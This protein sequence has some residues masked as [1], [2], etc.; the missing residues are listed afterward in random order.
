MAIDD[1]FQA[2]TDK[3]LDDRI[4]RPLR[5]PTVRPSFGSSVWNTTKA[6]FTG[7]GAGANESVGFAADILGA[8]GSVQAG[9]GLQADPTLLF[10]GAEKRREEG[11]KARAD[12][13]SGEAFSTELG[14]GFRATARS[15]SPDPATAN[16][17][18]QILFGLGRFATKA[19]GYSLAAGPVP[20]AV[21]AGADEGMTEADRLKAEGVDLST[22][23][24]V[25][26][27]AGVSTA[28]AVALP[29]AGKTLP[30]TI[31]LVA[32]GGPGGFIAQQ[33]A[34]RAILEH[35]DYGKIAEQYDPFDPVGLAVSTLVPAAF[36]AYALRGVRAAAKSPAASDPAAA[37]ELVQ[38]AGNER[39]AL[40]YDDP[41][42]DAYAITAAQ[43]EGIPPEALLAIKNVGEKS[44]P[45]A[46]SPKGAKGVMQFMDD[47][48][49]SY[50][51]GDARDPVASIDAG[52]RFMKDLIKQYDG[53]VRAAIAHYNGG[54]KAGKAVHAGELAPALETRK[55]LAR[56][57]EFL[58][59][60]QGE[61]AGRAAAN[62]PEAVAAARVALAREAIDSSNLH[63]AGDIRGADDHM[64]AVTRASD[65]LASGERVDVSDMVAP[66]RLDI[67]RVSDVVMRVQRVMEE[68]RA[69]AMQERG[70]SPR[71]IASMQIENFGDGFS[72]TVIDTAI[73]EGRY[74]TIRTKR[75]ED[76]KVITGETKVGAAEAVV[77]NGQGEEVGRLGYYKRPGGAHEEP[78]IF[79]SEKYR[80]QGVATA[81]YDHAERNGAVIPPISSKTAMR[82]QEGQA[83]R[84]AR[85]VT[86]A[87]E[88][89]TEAGIPATKV[90]DLAPN[91]AQTASNAKTDTNPMAAS[92]DAQSAE[93]ARLSPDMMVQLEGMEAPMRLTDALE[94]VKAEAA[95]DVRDAPLLQVAA[96][97]FLRSS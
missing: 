56:T 78:E 37:R 55:Y 31:G 47:T 50:G 15:F 20:G 94:A 92:L 63:A 12:M 62:D 27:V 43:R 22:R 74:D 2:S 84:A 65:Q 6:P 10:G 64:A 24:R 79:V 45:T 41:R 51:K 33:A 25:G 40:K 88:T 93:I 95:N 28:A 97:C 72:R 19:V 30:Q 4:A 32:A 91:Q 67:E 3:V 8:F 80:R 44:G 53:D 16:T 71:P 9:F 83:F 21:L 73:S 66:E 48:W 58:A 34:S 11:Q 49:N 86:K 61:Q 60:H 90:P 29:V 7:I 57:D 75:G 76:L 52:A 81:L 36:G 39:L 70:V 14:T 42:L 5:A 38:M 68:L 69:Q 96:E 18:E 23:A 89:G 1:L 13:A 35:A 54:T 87:G 17:A 77:I 82:S 59:Q 26:M 85:D 46:V